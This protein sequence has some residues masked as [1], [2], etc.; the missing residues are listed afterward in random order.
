[1]KDDEEAFKLDINC[2]VFVDFI[3]YKLLLIMGK[4]FETLIEDLD[5]K[6]KIPFFEKVWTHALWKTNYEN[7]NSIRNNSNSDNIEYDTKIL[8]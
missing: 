5:K 6:I 1:M 3:F 2:I 7:F 4:T 8:S